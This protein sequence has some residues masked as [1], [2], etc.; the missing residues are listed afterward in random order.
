MD[1]WTH[2]KINSASSYF[3]ENWQRYLSA[4]KNNTLYHHEMLSA[5]RLFFSEYMG[6]RSFSFVDVGCGDSSTVIPILADFP[7]NKYIGIDEAKDVLQM[8][9]NNLAHLHCEKEFIADN[10]IT[11]IPNLSTPVDI[12]YTSYAVHH[13]SLRDKIDFID[14]CKQKLT[15]HGFLL[16]IDGVL[17]HDQ[18]RS[19]WLDALKARMEETNPELTPEEISTRMEHPRS[20]DFPEAIM[21]FARIAQEQSWKDFKVIADKGIFAFIAFAK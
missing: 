18:T 5:L 20:D 21:T 12:I 3:N 17:T 13:L 14:N 6:T 8:A 11:A 9:S 16:M 7:I 2:S 15:K 10:M 4:V 1:K 19:Q